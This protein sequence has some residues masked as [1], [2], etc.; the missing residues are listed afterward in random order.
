MIRLVTIYSPPGV[1]AIGSTQVLPLATDVP[2]G[3]V[4][5]SDGLD[6]LT[7]G[8]YV[9]QRGQHDLADT[10][11]WVF[12]PSTAA[13]VYV[14]D[15][16]L[17]K[18]SAE[19]TAE[20]AASKRS[21]IRVTRGGLWLRISDEPVA[22]EAAAWMPTAKLTNDEEKTLGASKRSAIEKAARKQAK[23]DMK[24][25]TNPMLST[26]SP[27]LSDAENAARLEVWQ[28]L[29]DDYENEKTDGLADIV[30]YS[31]DDEAS[32]IMHAAMKAWDHFYDDESMKLSV[33]R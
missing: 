6:G 5:F 13:F 30:E 9:A 26:P 31:E 25:E 22:P 1:N 29:R 33:R 27:R 7:A 4:H 19:E 10:A 14:G 32:Y 16:L 15:L 20:L 12:R 18:A 8:R 21:S 3:T 17:R 24:A 28:S 2:V 23:A 11:V